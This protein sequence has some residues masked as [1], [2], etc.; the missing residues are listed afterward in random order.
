[1][2]F[3][4]PASDRRNTSWLKWSG[5]ISSANSSTPNRI[6][7]ICNIIHR[8]V[9]VVVCRLSSWSY[10]YVY[11]NYTVRARLSSAQLISWQFKTICSDQVENVSSL[12]RLLSKL[13]QLRMQIAIIKSVNLIKKKR[14]LHV[15]SRPL[16][17]YLSSSLHWAEPSRVEL[18]WVCLLDLGE[19]IA[20]RRILIWTCQVLIEKLICCNKW[21]S[22][23]C[24]SAGVNCVKAILYP[25]GPA[26][27]LERRYARTARQKQDGNQYNN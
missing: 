26:G 23:S 7:I 14:P 9:D 4:G 27:R 8:W 24:M 19:T 13:G 3:S 17:S 16:D 20:S 21:Q 2:F 18:S 25:T 11:L 22:L 5:E 15:P 6:Y 10:V 12:I 1:M